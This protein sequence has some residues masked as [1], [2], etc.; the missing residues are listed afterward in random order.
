MVASLTPVKTE[1]FIV[2]GTVKWFDPKRGLGFVLPDD[3]S[4]DVLVHQT[5]LKFA[6]HDIIYPGATLKCLIVRRNQGLR[7][8]QIIAEDNSPA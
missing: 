6:G 5:A 1:G 2:E 7:A 4:A 8:E 3:G